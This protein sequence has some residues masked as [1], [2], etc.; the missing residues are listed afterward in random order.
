MDAFA[1]RDGQPGAEDVPLSALAVPLGTPTCAAGDF[2][3]R[4]RHPVPEEGD[5]LA[6]HP[7]GAYG[8][9]M[10]SNYNTRCR[11]A[12]VLVDSSAAQTLR[13]QGT[14][15]ELFAGVNLQPD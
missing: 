8:F 6:V 15:Q 2:F 11:A 5:L 9:V 3:A 1:V 10:N 12:E 14:R 7:A 13:R 4:P